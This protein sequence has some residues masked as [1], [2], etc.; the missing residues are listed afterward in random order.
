[1]LLIAYESGL[2]VLWDVSEDHAVSV[3]GYGDLRM[4]GQING[5]QGILV[6]IN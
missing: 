2:L 4:K 6:K 5:A 3:R 1:M